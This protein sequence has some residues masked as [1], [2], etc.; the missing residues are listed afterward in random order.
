LKHTA[1]AR[2]QLKKLKKRAVQQLKSETSID[3]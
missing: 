1:S 3:S 2:P